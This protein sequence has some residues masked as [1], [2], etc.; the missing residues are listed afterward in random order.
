MSKKLKCFIFTITLFYLFVAAFMFVRQRNII[1]QPKKFVV[2]FSDN[3]IK[4]HGFEEIIIKSSDGLKLQAWYRKPGRAYL[5]VILYFHGNGGN[6]SNRFN[7]FVTFAEKTNYGVLALSYRGYGKSQGKPTEEGVYKDA[8]AAINFLLGEHIHL[9]EMIFYGESIGAAVATQMAIEFD[10]KALILE[11]PFTSLADIAQD[12]YWYLPAR[13]LLLDK[14]NTIEKISR[15]NMPLL[16]IHGKKDKVI[17]I[18]HGKA[19]LKVAQYPKKM[20]VFEENGHSDFNSKE[21]IRELKSF[22]EKL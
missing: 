17:P 7:K 4:K 10:A 6:L 9:E 2:M 18:Q 21:L 12:I 22:I 1:F 5:P 20:I 11:A 3:N 16:I 15:V 8:R 13:Y 19:L 14:F